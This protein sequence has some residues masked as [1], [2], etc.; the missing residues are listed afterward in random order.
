[1]PMG[2]AK[3]YWSGAG[4]AGQGLTIAVRLI[5]AVLA[6][7]LAITAQPQVHALAPCT[8]EL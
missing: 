2:W 6:V 1:M 5:R 4:R 8:G 7:S 3:S